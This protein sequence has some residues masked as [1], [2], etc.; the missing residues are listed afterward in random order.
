MDPI[1]SGLA[2]LARRAVKDELVSTDSENNQ[3]GHAWYHVV[4]GLF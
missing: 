3:A 2:H 1:A 4:G